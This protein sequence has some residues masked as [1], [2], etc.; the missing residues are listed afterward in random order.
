MKTIHDFTEQ[1]LNRFSQLL[2][3]A[4]ELID[5]TKVQKSVNIYN[6]EGE[7]EEFWDVYNDAAYPIVDPYSAL[8]DEGVNLTY[9]DR[10]MFE[11]L[12]EATES[13]SSYPECVRNH[14]SGCQDDSWDLFTEIVDIIDKVGY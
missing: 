4:Y 2:E 11:T 14:W 10:V 1:E 3:Q 5:W 6:S 7:T 8:M 9:V 13:A 12:T